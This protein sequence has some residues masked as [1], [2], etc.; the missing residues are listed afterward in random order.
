MLACCQQQQCQAQSGSHQL[1]EEREAH[2]QWVWGQEVLPASDHEGAHSEVLPC[3]C[4]LGHL[5]AT[6][7]CFEPLANAKVEGSNPFFCYIIHS[8]KTLFY[9]V[10][11]Y[12][13]HP[14]FCLCF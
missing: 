12:H 3:W 10:L 5:D 9:Y 4:S 8:V 13:C 2:D 1:E 6:H 7:P 11:M 14:I